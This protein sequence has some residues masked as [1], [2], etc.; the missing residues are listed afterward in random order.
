MGKVSVPVLDIFQRIEFQ[1]LL[2][3]LGLCYGFQVMAKILFNDIYP[4][5]YK[6]GI[7]VGIKS[8]TVCSL[9]EIKTASETQ[10]SG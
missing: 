9:F 8:V 1:L 3:R 6:D 7:K 10:H 4:I 5:C 2:T